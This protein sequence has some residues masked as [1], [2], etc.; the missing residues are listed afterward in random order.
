[1]YEYVWNMMH[2]DQ[3]LIAFLKE[4]HR[5]PSINLEEPYKIIKEKDEVIKDHKQ[6]IN[7]KVEEIK[8]HKQVI[9]E[10][11]EEIMEKDQVINMKD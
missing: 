1:M 7:K 3:D 8:D 11:D 10:K 5:L 2:I 4:Y 9:D 6:V